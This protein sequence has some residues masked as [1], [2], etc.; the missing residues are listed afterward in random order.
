MNKLAFLLVSMIALFCANNALAQSIEIVRQID[1]GEVIVK[2]NDSVH[3]INVSHFGGYSADPAFIFLSTPLSGIYRL[4][5]A[6]PGQT[7]SNVTIT[8]T[9]QV[10]TGGQQFN[11]DNFDIDYPSIVDG[12]GEAL[13]RVGARLR[14][15]GNG[16]MYYNLTDFLGFMDLEVTL[17]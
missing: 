11:I 7:I 1:F 6:T 12:S 10:T 4:R 14:T 9:Q 3:E 2:N 17:L 5:G 15:S 8:V 16:L 13:I